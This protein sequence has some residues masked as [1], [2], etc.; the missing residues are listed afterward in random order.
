MG[1]VAINA[2]QLQIRNKIINLTLS[3]FAILGTISIAL[4]FA[5]AYSTQSESLPYKYAVLIIIGWLLVVF[6]NKISL[7]F[8]LW[9][10][11]LMAFFVLLSGMYAFGF[12]ASAKIYVIVAPILFSFI[13]SYRKALLL[14][15]I[16]IIS[17]A[18]FAYLHINGFLNVNIDYTTYFKNK[19][20]WLLDGS[21]ITLVTFG[22]LFIGKIYNKSMSEQLGKA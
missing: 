6:R 14:F 20:T 11:A 21:I 3:W 16:L 18:L 17:Y 7:N 2:Y 15:F 12:H 19:Y 9:S 4:N 5:R 8:K 1:N 10:I 13:L 22:L